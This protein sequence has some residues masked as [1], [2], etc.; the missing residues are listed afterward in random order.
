MARYFFHLR[1]STDQLLDPDGREFDSLD[2]VRKAVLRDARD[3]ICG[4]LQTGIIDLRYWIDAEDG[5]GN[6]VYSL[7]F[8]H[9]FSIIP[10]VGPDTR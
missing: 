9:A 6:I 7:P 1:D 8:E 3:C 5:N 2:D 10:H 4:D